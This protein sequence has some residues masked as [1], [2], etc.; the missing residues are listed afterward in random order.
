MKA[1][2]WNFTPTYW[3]NPEWYENGVKIGELERIKE[4]DPA[5]EE[6]FSTTLNHL[7]GTSRNYATPVNSD[8]MFRIK[9]S[10][11]VRKGE[12]RVTDNFGNTYTQTI[13]W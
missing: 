9:P 11:G 10:D 8:Y 3:N 6:L 1:T 4:H 7:K 2:I 13:E 5:Y 12:V